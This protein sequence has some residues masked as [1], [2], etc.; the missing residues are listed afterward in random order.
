MLNVLHRLSPTTKQTLHNMG[1]VFGL[2]VRLRGL[3]ASDDLRLAHFLALH[4]INSVI[5][6][7]ANEGQF[8]ELLFDAGYKGDLISFEALPDAHA[9][10][11]KKAAQFGGAWRVGPQVALSDR[12]GLAT[13]HVT[14]AATSSSLLK[15]SESFVA[16][17]PSVCIEA[18]I[19][20]LTERLDA[21]ADLLA[22]DDR[23]TFLK[24]DVQGAEPTV[25]AGAERV[26][27]SICGMLVEMSL[28]ELYREQELAF[29]LHR[30]ISS[31]GFELWDI[32][33]GYRDP[34]NYRLT[35]I[36]GVYFRP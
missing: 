1:R 3:G 14:A 10:L 35:Q 32:W 5:D 2:E 11:T 6:V 29:D 7:G 34:R 23:R 16:G 19:E 12:K 4:D 15:P 17:T 8:G 31:M 21:F 25:L 13:F 28:T 20:V 36:D 9:K 30:L 27:P 18:E 26:L 22:I 24:L 33:L